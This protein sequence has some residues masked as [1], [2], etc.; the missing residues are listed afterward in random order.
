MHLYL[1]MRAEETITA[2]DHVCFLVIHVFQE[3]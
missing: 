3:N 2:A 1:M